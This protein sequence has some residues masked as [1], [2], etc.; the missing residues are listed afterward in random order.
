MVDVGIADNRRAKPRPDGAAAK[1]IVL[2]IPHPEPLVEQTDR[3][4]DL[5][6]NQQAKADQARR[7][8]KL[9]R[10]A[11][12]MI[13]R[14]P[15]QIGQVTIRNDNLLRSADTVGARAGQTEPRVA[16]KRRK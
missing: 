6:A 15:V 5:P 4:N 7:R 8:V 12:R 11:P 16:L 9:A 2:E 10:M 1:I 3:I 14:E 13:R